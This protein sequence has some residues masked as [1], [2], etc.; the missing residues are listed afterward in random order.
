MAVDLSDTLV[1]GISATALFDLSDADRVFR[2]KFKEDKETA[3]SEYRTYMQDRE[4]S[5]GVGPYAVN[6]NISNRLKSCPGNC[7]FV[8]VAP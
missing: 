5:L 7:S 3:V 6:G 1:I 4:K 8:P 2:S